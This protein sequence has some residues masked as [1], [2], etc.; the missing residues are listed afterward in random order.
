L[1]VESMGCQSRFSSNVEKIIEF[2]NYVKIF[3]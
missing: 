1:G 3:F 2:I